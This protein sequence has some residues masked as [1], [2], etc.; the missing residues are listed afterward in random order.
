MSIG[1]GFLT[2]KGLS[3]A[4]VY[5]QPRLGTIT[6]L[7]QPHKGVSTCVHMQVEPNHANQNLQVLQLLL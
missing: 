2:Q 4:A 3:Q 7:L 1:G 5:A 6:V